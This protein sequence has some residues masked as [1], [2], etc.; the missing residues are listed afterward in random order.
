VC[1]CAEL[2]PRPHALANDIH[3]FCKR[4]PGIR[5]W[6]RFKIFIDLDSALGRAQLV[7][8]DLDGALTDGRIDNGRLDGGTTAVQSEN[9]HAYTSDFMASLTTRRSAPAPDYARNHMWL[10]RYA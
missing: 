3:Y 9:V 5:V 8:V 2:E 1:D 10:R 7:D 6:Q 4:C